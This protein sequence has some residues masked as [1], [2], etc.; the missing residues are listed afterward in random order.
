MKNIKLLSNTEIVTSLQSLVTEERKLTLEILEHLREI[1]V[2][3][4]HS[5]ARLQLAP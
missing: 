5:T 4:L 1:E 2:R 3:R